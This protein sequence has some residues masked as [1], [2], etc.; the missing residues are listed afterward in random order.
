MNDIYR[1]PHSELVETTAVGAGDFY[2]VAKNKF[3]ILFFVTAGIY[4]IYW[5]YKNWSLQKLKT[6]ES[7]MPVWRA[8]F[9]IFFT[10]S[11]FARINQSLFDQDIEF[12]WNPTLAATGY[13]IVLIVSSILDR[14]SYA[15]IGS[16]VTDLLSILILGVEGYILYKAQ[17]AINLAAGD[18]EGRDNAN[19]TAANYFW[20]FVG[21][22]FWFLI[23]VGFISMYQ[24]GYFEF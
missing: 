7:I 11:L 13:V 9:M 21:L 15:Y 20:C 5:F 18:P 6:G 17:L 10:H 19:F 23:L 3:L 14:L 16:P 24:E 22:V 4:P 12:K 1:P 8:I 2:V